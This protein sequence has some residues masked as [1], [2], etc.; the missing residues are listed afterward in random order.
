MSIL[1]FSQEGT[2]RQKSSTVYSLEGRNTVR[3]RVVQPVDPLHTHTSD[4]EKLY[5]E[6]GGLETSSLSN[7][8]GL[9]LRFRSETQLIYHATFPLSLAS[10]LV[11]TTTRRWEVEEG[12]NLYQLV[13]KSAKVPTWFA[14]SHSFKTLPSALAP[15]KRIKVP[16]QRRPVLL[17]PP[18]EWTLEAIEWAESW[19]DPS[20]PS[21]SCYSLAD[22]DIWL[23]YYTFKYY[24]SQEKETVLFLSFFLFVGCISHATEKTKRSS[25]AWI[26]WD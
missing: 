1:S 8:A 11:T 9:W 16:S 17:H 3:C 26:L 20:I 22:L 6:C 19:L 14:T 12:G 2:D 15:Y 24:Q 5:F 4:E 23:L 7:L 10:P 13:S 21:Y 18:I 25:A